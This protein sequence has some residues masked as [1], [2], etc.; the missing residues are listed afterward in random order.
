MG[1]A[2]VLGVGLAGCSGDDGSTGP[3]GPAGPAG[4]TGPEGPPGPSGTSS[5]DASTLSPAAFAALQIQATVT[6]VAIASP[7]VV[8]FKLAT[9]DG[10]PIVGFGSTSKSS[11]AT[12]AS[13]P[14]LAFSIAKLEPGDASN[15]SQWVNYIVTTVPT[16]TT[17]NAAPQ[18]PG[19][20][21]TGTLVDNKDGTY[22]YTFYRD[23]T[24]IKDQVAAMSV[25]PPN[26]KADLG[27]LTYNPNLSHRLTIQISGNA[28][29]TGTNTP[30]AVQTMPGVPLDRP[31][32][33]IYDFIPATGQAA[34]SG[35]EMVDNGNCNTCHQQLG[36][37]PGISAENDV[38]QFHGG[39]RNTIQY[40]VICH[41]NQRKYGRTEATFNTTSTART[42]TS[43]TYR[44][45]DY[46]VGTARSFLHKVHLGEVLAM[47]KYNYANVEFNET[48]YPQDIRNC[49]KCHDRLNAATPQASNWVNKPSAEACG[50]CHD[51]INFRTGFGV[52]LA[53]A[54]AG[55]GTSSFPPNGWAHIGGPQVDNSSCGSAN[56]HS[57][58]RIDAVHRPV[59]P[60]NPNNS[61]LP[62]GTNNN[63]NAAWLASNQNRLPEG[64]IKVGYDIKSTSR[65]ASGQPV[66]VFRLLQDGNPVP[67][68]N[69][70]TAAVNPATG[71]KE[72]WANFMGSPSV[73][74]VYAAKQDG[75]ATPSEFNA[76]AQAYLRTLWYCN[77]DGG[78]PGG[79]VCPGTLTGPDADGYYTAT[80]TKTGTGSTA[81]DQVIPPPNDPTNPSSMLTG[82]LGYSYNVRSTLP[83][84]QTN[85]M[86]YPAQPST[87]SGLTAG[88]P[89]ATG[90]LV[91]IVPN[92]QVVATGYTGRRDLVS[93]AKCNACHQE[94]GAFVE[95]A[96]HAGQRNDARTCSW[97]HTPNRT[98]SGWTADSTGFVHSIHAAGV[99]N[100]NAA[101]GK[102][103]T[104]HATSAD[105][106]F[107][108]IGYPGVLSDCEGCHISGMYDFSAA[109]AAAAAPNR[110]FRTVASGNLTTTA[111]YTLS[112]W[113]MPI[114]YGSGPS[115]TANGVYTQGA[116][117]NLVTSPT[118]T[119]C[120]ACHVSNDAQSHMAL[121]GGS[122]YAA[123][124]TATTPNLGVVESCDVCHGP[125]RIAAIGTV[126][127]R[128]SK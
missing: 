40:C 22:Q 41:T 91:V 56:C 53:D 54:A 30:N 36:G 77:N 66:M 17:P 8:K 81:V 75:I 9:A 86:A 114:N 68:Q 85:L 63:T 104:W 112:P 14:N 72:I 27:D 55:K 46:G 23:I 44:L 15:P 93:E 52:T 58:A 98:S 90:G 70:A 61:L 37:L 103:Y 100:P 21:N 48:L 42:F 82:G 115:M 39:G 38:A 2:L 88:M 4:P 78:V 113:V 83:L 59:T 121:N 128:V 120:L 124:G 5:V 126:H 20:D 110:L 74:F 3:A 89:N 111:S 84:T 69:F 79:T 18:R 47:Q 31:V 6:S 13:Y 92:T 94:L 71:Q 76:T 51:G 10:T 97:C 108:Q 127:A 28:P 119:V 73:Y 106:G 50:A 95:D 101:N 116:A 80:I 67:L 107:W 32:D 35:R 12:V 29:G 11:T 102:F 105:Q 1:A 57:P 19:T 7:P 123:R 87:V 24:T 33:V 43:T 49:D 62:G 45:Y 25:S 64:A 118:T 65:N 122:I 109:A 26:N 16:T 60:P 117:T 99:L 34:P 125:G 96:F